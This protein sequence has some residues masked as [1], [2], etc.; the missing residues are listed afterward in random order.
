MGAMVVFAMSFCCCCCPRFTCFWCWNAVPV[1]IMVCLS[2]CLVAN[3]VE[4][5]YGCSYRLAAGYLQAEVSAFTV[6]SSFIN[7]EASLQCFDWVANWYLQ[8]LSEELPL[9]LASLNFK[10]SMR[11]RGSTAFSRPLRWLLALH[12]STAL[13][14]TYAGISASNTTRLLRNSS[15]PLHQV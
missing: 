3:L 14:L 9:L 8:V 4:A 13:P 11:W 2:A 7:I 10:R 15:S 1:P 5:E 6:R 12:D